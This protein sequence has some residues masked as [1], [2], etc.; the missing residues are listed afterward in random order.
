MQRSVIFHLTNLYVHLLQ[1]PSTV[2]KPVALH[3]YPHGPEAQLYSVKMRHIEKKISNKENKDDKEGK[4][5]KIERKGRKLVIFRRYA[6]LLC[7]ENEPTL[8]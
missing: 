8:L 5:W 1:T 6:V 4:N 3:Y 7:G 2:T